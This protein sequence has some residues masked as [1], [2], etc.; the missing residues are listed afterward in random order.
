MKK[1][2]KKGFTL[3]ELLA[4]LVILAALATIAIPIFMNKGAEARLASHKENIRVLEDAAQ[5]YEWEE[6]RPAA[7][8][9]TYY[10]EIVPGHVLITK[11]YLKD[12]PVNPYKNA[13]VSGEEGT[14]FIYAIGKST[15]A[16]RGNI[17][18]AKLIANGTTTEP[19]EVT[20]AGDIITAGTGVWIEAKPEIKINAAG[21]NV[22]VGAIPAVS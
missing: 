7:D 1:L 3:L 2:N 18:E 19:S 9:T 8:T 21:D 6:G 16:S 22:E 4:V 15:V 13:T 11:G 14:E 12:V 17:T 10:T 5:R 20:A